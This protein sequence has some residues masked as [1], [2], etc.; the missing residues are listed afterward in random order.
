V[1]IAQ[2]GKSL[3]TT[4]DELQ[5]VQGRQVSAQFILETFDGSLLVGEDG[6]GTYEWVIKQ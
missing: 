5:T 6:N 4:V 1:E 2:R 3:E